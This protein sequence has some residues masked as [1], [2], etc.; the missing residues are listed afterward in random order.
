MSVLR[1]VISMVWILRPSLVLKPLPN[2]S[3][4]DKDTEQRQT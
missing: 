3:K 2:S 4:D 1:D